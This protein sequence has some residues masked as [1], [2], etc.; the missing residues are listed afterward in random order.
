M[1]KVWENLS[2]EELCDLMCGGP[3][4]EEYDD[5]TLNEG[6]SVSSVRR[7]DAEKFKESDKHSK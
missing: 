7:E 6:C 2:P 5:E 4:D 3:E 1:G